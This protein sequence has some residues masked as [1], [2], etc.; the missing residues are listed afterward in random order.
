MSSATSTLQSILDDGNG[1]VNSELAA[2][3]YEWEKV[4]A[5]QSTKSVLKSQFSTRDGLRLVDESARVI[6]AS[7][8]PPT[9]DDVN[10]L[11]G[12]ARKSSIS[13]PDLVQE[14]MIALLHA[15]STYNSYKTHNK[16]DLSFE[17]YAQQTIQS[18]LLHFLAHSS[19][20]IRLPFSLQTTLQSANEAAAKLRSALGR[21]P[22]LTQVAK[23]VNI[24]AH[25]L[26]LYRKLHRTMVRRMETFV[27]M[28]DGFE[29]Y[30]PTTVGSVNSMMFA[31]DDGDD[32]EMSASTDEML[33][34]PTAGATEEDDWE[35]NN[36]ERTVAP[37]RDILTD[38][39]EINNPLSYTQHYLLTQELD[40]FLYETLTHDELEV[41]QL[42]FGLL[43]SKYGGK[44][45]SAGQIGERMNMDKEEVV[46]IA[47]S[48]L[49]KL[50]KAKTGD[51]EIDDPFIEV[52][53]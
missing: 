38:T 40:Q 48:A 26:A 9:S 21:E 30:D 6:L 41:I 10:D 22:T 19:R 35:I 2:A 52:T 36:P 46:K 29:V 18:S 32:G 33:S 14:G 13:Y 51:W 25:Q 34:S 49:E 50:R 3:I 12:D 16:N 31:E 28:E 20:P 17:K 42:R 11:T 47:S 53:L 44:G 5:E 27:S 7:L 23:E 15:I 8:L 39:E 37:L 43:D 1:H 4:H 24:D 45:W